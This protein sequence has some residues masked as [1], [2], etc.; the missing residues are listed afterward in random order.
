MCGRQEDAIDKGKLTLALVLVAL[1]VAL[2]LWWMDGG[3][4]DDV[5]I[6]EGVPLV[7]ENSRIEGLEETQGASVSSNSWSVQLVVTDDDDRPVEGASAVDWLAET[8][9]GVTSAQGV[10]IIR[11][12]Q[13]LL[14][15]AVSAHGFASEIHVFEKDQLFENGHVSGP[16]PC[17]LH[18]LATIEVVVDCD[19]LSESQQEIEISLVPTENSGVLSVE[20]AGTHFRL[21]M[22]V[23]Q[24]DASVDVALLE[25]VHQAIQQFQQVRFIVS[26]PPDAVLAVDE[27]GV[28]RFENLPFDLAYRFRVLSAA[29]FDYDPAHEVVAA[30]LNPAGSGLI[31]DM[32]IHDIP[33]KDLS[34]AIYVGSGDVA[35]GRAVCQ[36][37][38]TVSGAIVFPSVYDGDTDVILKSHERVDLNGDGVPDFGQILVE[39]SAFG[40]EDG[41]F[42]FSDI[43]APGDKIIRANSTRKRP[44][45]VEEIWILWRRF[46][47]FEGENRLGELYPLNVPPIHLIIEYVDEKGDRL[48]GQQF[49]P[50]LP[51]RLE[52]YLDVDIESSLDKKDPQQAVFEVGVGVE[53]VLYG[54]P[55]DRPRLRV[56]VMRGTHPQWGN[57]RIVEPARF[58]LSPDG[59][60]IL[61]PV[62]RIE[63]GTIPVN[64]AGGLLTLHTRPIVDSPTI[65]GVE[66]KSRSLTIP[67]GPH[68]PVDIPMILARGDFSLLVTSAEAGEYA[69]IPSTNLGELGRSPP[70]QLRPGN[71]LEVIVSTSSG[72]PISGHVIRVG[73]EGW[74]NPIWWGRTDVRGVITFEG[75]LPEVELWLGKEKNKLFSGEPGAY[76]RTEVTV[77]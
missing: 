29:P 77:Q 67:E 51:D 65:P 52:A 5:V 22:D 24:D 75:V 12:E 33:V 14:V 53:T 61:I 37:T 39:A 66:H 18:R 55:V 36:R 73:I 45:G 35:V 60:R 69:W 74:G 17:T 40:D 54:L 76:I 2:L 3:P 8:V 59:N 30:A 71:I 27:D 4:A 15:V 46:R 43:L 1:G 28:A 41:V 44:D 26:T 58:D 38:A 20:Q 62:Q 70:I 64:V 11:S 6:S 13:D 31:V 72:S 56:G 57:R 50:P 48:S 47:C 10:L 16:V 7:L 21:F 34:G 42:E 9:Y 25:R 68:R 19:F 23:E 49:D 32:S 63:H